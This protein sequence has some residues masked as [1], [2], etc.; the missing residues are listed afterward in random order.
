MSR[1]PAQRVTKSMKLR[2]PDERS[3]ARPPGRRARAGAAAGAS[4][5]LR[6]AR[7]L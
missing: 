3:T 4:S 2:D 7:G 1:R 5:Q 6:V